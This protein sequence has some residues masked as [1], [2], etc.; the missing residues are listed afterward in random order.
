MVEPKSYQNNLVW[1]AKRTCCHIPWQNSAQHDTS[2]IHVTPPKLL[3][4]W[5]PGMFPINT[6]EVCTLPA[7]PCSFHRSSVQSVLA[8]GSPTPK[9]MR[10]PELKRPLSTASS[11]GSSDVSHKTCQES[12]QIQNKL[13]CFWGWDHFKGDGWCCVCGLYNSRTRGGQQSL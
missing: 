6:S 13:T 11:P 5:A 3:G 10:K 4:L 1:M 7:W 12:N 9:C 8:D 2:Q